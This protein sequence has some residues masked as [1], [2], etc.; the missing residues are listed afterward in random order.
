MVREAIEMKNIEIGLN[1]KNVVVT[2]L[3]DHPQQQCIPCEEA[4]Y[5]KAVQQGAEQCD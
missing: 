2:E 4:Q 1:R 3:D 5:Q